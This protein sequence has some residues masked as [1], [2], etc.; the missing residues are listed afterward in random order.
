MYRRKFC[1]CDTYF[2]VNTYKNK[3]AMGDYIANPITW[4]YR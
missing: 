4:W 1:G 2:E 3:V